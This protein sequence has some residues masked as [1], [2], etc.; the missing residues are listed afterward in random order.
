M[1]SDITLP[2]LQFFT[3]NMSAPLRNIAFNSSTLMLFISFASHLSPDG[4][5]PSVT[6]HPSVL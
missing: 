2:C 3:C 1:L 4:L 6:P 5:F